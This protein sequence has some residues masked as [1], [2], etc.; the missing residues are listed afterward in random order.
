MA[1][2]GLTDLKLDLFIRVYVNAGQNKFIW[3]KWPSIGI[4]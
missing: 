1:N 4:K 3:L 2:L